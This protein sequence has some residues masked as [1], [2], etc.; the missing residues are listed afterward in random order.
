MNQNAN[1]T[2]LEFDTPESMRP[3]SL[4]S[5]G[6]DSKRSSKEEL[7]HLHIPSQYIGSA[8]SARVV[9]PTS[10][11]MVSRRDQRMSGAPTPLRGALVGLDPMQSEP[12][13]YLHNP[14]RHVHKQSHAPTWRGVIN[15]ATLIIIVLALLML[16]AGYPLLSHYKHLY[17][18][19]MSQAELLQKQTMPIPHRGLI[20]LD[21]P[22]EAKKP[23]KGAKTNLEYKLVFSDEFNESGRTFWPGDDPFFEALDAWYS[24]T[25]DYEWYTP[26]A[27]NTTRI[28]T[29]TGEDGFLTLTLEEVP[30]HNFNFR[31]A[32]VT[33]WNKL[34]FQGGYMETE[35][36]FPDK[37]NS[38]GYWPAA[39]TM[40]NLGRP[41][42]LG[43]TQGMWPYVYDGCD[44]GILPNQTEPDGEGPAAALHAKQMG[45]DRKRI[46][47]LPGMRTPSCTCP[48]EDHPGPRVDVARGV[49]EIDI[50]ET[51]VQGKDYSSASQSYQVGPFDADYNWNKNNDTYQIFDRDI[52]EVN[53]Y[54]GSHDQE[55]MSI[56]SKI[57]DSA[58]FETDRRP[59]KFGVEYVPDKPGTHGTG[60]ITW[61]LDGK[62]TWH[63]KGSTLAPDPKT[64]IGWRTIPAEPLFA[65]LNLGISS[66]FQ[67]ISSYYN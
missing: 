26:E 52:S 56:V 28:K 19:G 8:T 42:Y 21:T 57:P 18:Q 44:V 3:M 10:G 61:Y 45:G 6:Y 27:A 25:Q 13:D 64:K 32:M 60:S 23:F 50:F 55:A 43:T 37:P 4:N 9:S 65:I 40:G 11:N 67:D 38:Q 62:P 39:W 17:N 54:K 47:R 16:F 30:E 31:S 51:Q 15:V 7:R 34:C 46:S 33:S 12:D 14:D 22:P 41:G 49:P 36:I 48:G 1:E 53:T 59:C 35:V 20:D 2:R 5:S 29:D 58:F 24:G 63:L 66:G